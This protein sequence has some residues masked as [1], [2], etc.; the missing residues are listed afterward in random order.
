ML[1]TSGNKVLIES[2][3]S[4]GTNSFASGYDSKSIGDYSQALG[5]NARAFGDNSTAIGNFANATNAAYLDIF[6]C[7]FYEPREVAEFARSFFKGN[8]YKMQIALRQ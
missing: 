1:E 5:Y 6:S 3:D 8:N 2:P 7:K 4:V